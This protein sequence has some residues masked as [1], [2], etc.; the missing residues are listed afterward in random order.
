MTDHSPQ[1]RRMLLLTGLGVFIVFLDTTIVNVA[2]ET[3]RRAF[4]ADLALLVWVLNAYTLVFAAVLIPAGRMSDTYGARRLFHLGLS[5]FAVS[6]LVC[7]LAP[8]VEVLIA[9]RVVQGLFG[10][11]I[12]PASL[13]LLLRTVPRAKRAAA[14]SA[15]G[16]MGAVATAIGPTLGALLIEHAGWRWIFLV[17]LPVCL[18][19]VAWGRGLVPA[20]G[21][22]RGEGA[23]DPLGVVLSGVG[24]ALLSFGVIY[25]P[26]T[27][28]TDPRV[29][30]ALLLG[31]LTVLWFVRRAR[32]VARPAVDP[33]L[34]RIRNYVAST[35]VTLVF[36]VSFF[37][38]LLSSLLFMQN[39]WHYSP[40]LA[41]LAVSP[42]AL[43]TALVAPSVGGLAKRFGYRPV[44]VAG[45]LCYAAGAALLATRVNDSPD[46]LADWLPTLVL[47]GIGVGLALSAANSAAAD[48]LPEDRFG[49]GIAVNNSFRQFGGVLG[50]SLLV[51]VLGASGGLGAYQ[52]VWW[53]LAAITLVSAVLYLALHRDEPRAVRRA[54]ADSPD[55]L[56]PTR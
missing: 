16:A 7:G 56:A 18:A 36:S 39:V 38:I 11:M 44:F 17:N 50:V 52:R 55:S 46:W 43:I 49:V 27:G 5:G 30:G 51:A 2:F 3:V 54:V 47:N 42:A 31:V 40:L 23:P 21:P 13:T 25:G 19:A 20:D 45:A 12:V 14:V 6:S 34:F 15:W 9:A 4:D 22:V 35:V 1:A 33:A 32:R 53:L 28:W 24:P 10:A 41:A 29:A 37:A 26:R 8:S 48:S